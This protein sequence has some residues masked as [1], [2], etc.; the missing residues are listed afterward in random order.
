MGY[1]SLENDFIFL[2]D[3]LYA[4][5]TQALSDN[6]TELKTLHPD[7]WEVLTNK[8]FV[9]SAEV[10][11][12]QQVKGLVYSI[13]YDS[14]IY[15]LII[16]PTLNCNF[17][18]WYCYETHI[19]GSKMDNATIEKVKKHII[20]EL[21]RKNTKHL[22]ISWFGGEPLLCYKQV[23]LPILEFANQYTT[24][25]N[26]G[27]NSNFTSNGVL[28]SDTV[29]GSF[30]RLKIDGFQITLDGHRD[31][32]N[33]VRYFSNKKGSYDIIVSN[34]KKCLK[35]K[36]HV[37][38]RINI[39]KDTFADIEKVIDDFSDLPTI[40]RGY[41]VFSFQQV[42]QEVTDIHVQILELIDLFKSHG[43]ATQYNMYLD[44]VRNSCYA[45]KKHQAIINYNGDVFKCS[46]RDFTPENREG[47]LKKDGTIEW[48][49]KYYARMNIKFKN[50][51]C[52]ECKILPI[53]NGG[54]SQKAIECQNKNY[55]VRDFDENRKLE[56]VRAKL[57]HVL[58]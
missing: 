56:V 19:K 4:L 6:I 28:I 35:H 57:E 40:D 13:D 14:D 50:P 1:N 16:N 18:C 44:S 21:S 27:F 9:V 39:S 12:L 37:T 36:V 10:D 29:L 33:N 41:L 11:P 42:W 26:I 54:C 53:C 20:G 30:E 51:P 2:S 49:E 8:H 25:K 17:K 46:A 24:D 5:Y 43:F 47:I 7:F 48:N 34:I 23:V 52:M 3:E 15:H 32:H 58:S 22:T 31:R 45:D 38:C 55:C